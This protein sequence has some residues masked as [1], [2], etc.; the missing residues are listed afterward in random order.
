[1]S[2]IQFTGNLGAI[3]IE[4]IEFMYHQ[5]CQRVAPLPG[6]EVEA[7]LQEQED[8]RGGPMG[9]GPVQQQ[10]FKFEM[11]RMCGPHISRTITWYNGVVVVAV[12][13]CDYFQR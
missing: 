9:L 7:K 2:G 8:I 1:M 13:Q 4:L 12:D 5:H 6:L 3:C 10:S 11:K